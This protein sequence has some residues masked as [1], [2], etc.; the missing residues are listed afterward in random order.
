MS[1]AR[2]L[3]LTFFAFFDRFDEPGDNRAV[4]ILLIGR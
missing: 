4:G 2:L 3:A 1:N